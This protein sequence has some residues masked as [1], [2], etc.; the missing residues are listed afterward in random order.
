MSEGLRVEAANVEDQMAAHLKKAVNHFIDLKDFLNDLPV[1][2]GPSGYPP[3]SAGIS[4]AAD[5]GFRRAPK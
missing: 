5:S 2:R 3:G 4:P 1:A